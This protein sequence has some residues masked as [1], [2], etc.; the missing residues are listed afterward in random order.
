MTWEFFTK[1][2]GSP[3]AMAYLSR[4]SDQMSNFEWKT[5][6]PPKKLGLPPGRGDVELFDTRRTKEV[7]IFSRRTRRGRGKIL[8]GTQELTNRILNGFPNGEF[9]RV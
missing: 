9:R 7:L 2:R 6:N 1:Q 3:T 8:A 5:I 4:I